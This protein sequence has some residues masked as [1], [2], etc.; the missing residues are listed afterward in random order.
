ME[1]PFGQSLVAGDTWNWT[2]DLSNETVPYSPS[3]GYTLKYFFRG[4]Q[5]LDLMA[6]ASGSAFSVTATPAQT[7]A[8][9]PGIYAWQA[10]VFLSGDRT[11]LARGTVEILPDISSQDVGFETRSWVKQSLDAVRAVL[12]NRAGRIEKEYQIAGRMLM[13]LTPDELLKLE[14]DLTERYQ[15]ELRDSGQIARN[16]SRIVARFV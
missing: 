2:V 9:P 4:A 11:E 5:S 1:Q 8:L 7:K 6:S 15:K 13:L 16:S 3:A 10:A 14:G 12:Q